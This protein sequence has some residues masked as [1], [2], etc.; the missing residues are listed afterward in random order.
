MQT[1]HLVLSHCTYICILEQ[2]TLC[3]DPQINTYQSVLVTDGYSSYAVFIY[4]CGQLAS[5]SFATMGYY[6]NN[7]HFEE[8]GLSS[9]ELVSR[10]SCVNMPQ[11]PWSNII[12]NFTGMWC[13][14]ST[15]YSNLIVSYFVLKLHNFTLRCWLGDLQERQDISILHKIT[16]FISF[17]DVMSFLDYIYGTCKKM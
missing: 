13:P 5:T 4:R 17:F 1:S 16:P 11:S 15:I 6:I 9:T 8:P 3:L 12:Y 7:Y 14:L 2:F 10:I